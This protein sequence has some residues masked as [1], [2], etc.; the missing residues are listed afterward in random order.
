MFLSFLVSNKG[1]HGAASQGIRIAI[2]LLPSAV[3]ARPPVSEALLPSAVLARP[4]I[5]GAELPSAVLARPPISGALLPCAVL[6]R[7]SISGALLPCLVLVCL[8]ISRALLPC[9]V[10]ICL[11]IRVA[12]L[13]CLVLVC[14]SVRVA[15]LL[16]LSRPES[17]GPPTQVLETKNHL[18]NLNYPLIQ[19][20]C[21]SV[22]LNYESGSFLNISAVITKN[23]LS[24][25]LRTAQ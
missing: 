7:L 19:N 17:A 10:L 1:I 14:L 18:E 23:R 5:S 4:P 6:A 8:S 15:V 13:P 11:S 22:I 21:G 12:V 25:S 24:K 20:N 9:L 16:F 2:Q 3:L